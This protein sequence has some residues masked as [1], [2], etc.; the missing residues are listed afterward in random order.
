[1]DDSK[2]NEQWTIWKIYFPLKM[3]MIHCHVFLLVKQGQVHV[4]AENAMVLFGFCWVIKEI[5]NY[6]AEAGVF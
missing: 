3:D 1:M 4:S 5:S 6:A 2:E